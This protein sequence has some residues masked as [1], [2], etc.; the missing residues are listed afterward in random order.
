[1]VFSGHMSSGK[2]TV[3]YGSFIPSFLKDSPYSSPSWLYQFTVPSIVEEGSLF[4]TSSP[5]FIVCSFVV[6]VVLRI[7]ILTGGR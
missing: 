2:I 7:A 5:V 4:S 3:S 1:M 6:V